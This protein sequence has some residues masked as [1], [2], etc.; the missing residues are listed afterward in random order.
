MRASRICPCSGRRTRQSRAGDEVQGAAHEL[1]AG[2]PA[3]LEQ[4]RELGRVEVPDTGPEPDVG[5]ERLLRLQAD[6][7]LD[8]LGDG[9][10]AAFHQELARQQRPVQLTAAEHGGHGAVRSS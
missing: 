5:L 7:V 4:L 2:G 10:G 8:R 9:R 6:E 1:R 3:R